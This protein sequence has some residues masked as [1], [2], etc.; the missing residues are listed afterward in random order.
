MFASSDT[1]PRQGSSQQQEQQQQ[2]SELIKEQDEHP[3]PPATTELTNTSTD[4]QTLQQNPNMDDLTN[5]AIVFQDMIYEIQWRIIKIWYTNSLLKQ[6]KASVQAFLAK[7]VYTNNM[8]SNTCEAEIIMFQFFLN[9]CTL[10]HDR[11]KFSEHDEQ[12]QLY[13]KLGQRLLL[14][15]D[16]H[17][18]RI[19]K[20]KLDC[21]ADLGF[22][23]ISMVKAVD[24]LIVTG[25]VLV[26]M[27]ELGN[28]NY[29]RHV[30]EL[31]LDSTDQMQ[32]FIDHP[33]VFHY[34]KIIRIEGKI[35][36][37]RRYI[38]LFH[39]FSENTISKGSI[40]VVMVNI[41]L[42]D[43]ATVSSW[44]E[45]PRN[46]NIKLQFNIVQKRRLAK[47]NDQ[48]MLTI[49]NKI[50]SANLH[51]L[52]FE[53]G[54]PSFPMKDFNKFFQLRHLTMKGRWTINGELKFLQLESLT[55][56]FVRV[57]YF[58]DVGCRV[59]VCDRCHIGCKQLP[60]NV[61]NL[62]LNACHISNFTMPEYVEVVDI[63]IGKKF[64]FP[65][66]D[67]LTRLRELKLHSRLVQN[68]HIEL[69]NTITVLDMEVKDACDFNLPDQ[70]ITLKERY[71]F[72]ASYPNTLGSMRLRL[73]GGNAT[74]NISS[75]L[76]VLHL[77]TTEHASLVVYLKN[78]Q[79][80]N[81]LNIS[82]ISPYVF[83]RVFTDTVTFRTTTTDF[84]PN[85]IHNVSTSDACLP[86]YPYGAVPGFARQG[87][88]PQ[89]LV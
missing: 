2:N 25:E 6:N 72:R 68:R 49:L 27:L 34:L 13:S 21:M 23:V 83:V 59:L 84:N 14:F 53:I 73:H 37:I 9:N 36:F 60:S 71:R 26:K 30:D 85:G 74:V 33:Y 32:F 66:I 65:E 61:R 67:Q 50:G 55:L 5:F 57:Q 82:G 86:Y 62:R 77:D 17:K 20:I 19:P 48:R 56:S 76:K 43:T 69:P 8:N 38:E 22:S 70:L 1:L 87:F 78:S 31:I 51:S 75:S 29:L 40:P 24:R 44:E 41:H 3:I 15:I 28:V 58:G 10:T 42:D 35:S 88:V 11:I 54:M 46:L 47:D 79:F 64:M 12:I 7:L 80:L 52:R 18:I 81:E 89:R 4:T 63:T 39:A 45:L 16:E